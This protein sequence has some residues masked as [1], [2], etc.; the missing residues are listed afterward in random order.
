[1]P[2][3]KDASALPV[4]AFT[5]LSKVAVV[6]VTSLA[7]RVVTVGAGGEATMARVCDAVVPLMAATP[8]A[9]RER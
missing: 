5:V 6:L 7:A 4:F 9:H 2:H 1:M 3:S 8:L